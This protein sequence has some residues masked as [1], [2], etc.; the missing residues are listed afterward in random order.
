MPLMQRV[1]LLGRS[2]RRPTRAQRNAHPALVLGGSRGKV[3][4]PEQDW[5]AAD[6]LT[7][8]HIEESLSDEIVSNTA[9]SDASGEDVRERLVFLSGFG[10]VF[11]LSSM[12]SM[13]RRYFRHN[14]RLWPLIDTSLP[15]EDLA[16]FL[17]QQG[18]MPRE[19]GMTLDAVP[20][21][22]GVST[23][24]MG[25]RMLR[26]KAL[27][28]EQR[29]VLRLLYRV[30]VT[31]VWD[32]EYFDM[33]AEHFVD[34]CGAFGPA[35]AQHGLICMQKAL[36]GPWPRHYLPSAHASQLN[37]PV[38]IGLAEFLDLADPYHHVDLFEAWLSHAA[39]ATIQQSTTHIGPERELR[40][41][42]LEVVEDAIAMIELLQ[43]N[44]EQGKQLYGD[45]WPARVVRLHG[46]PE[47]LLWEPQH[48]EQH[49]SATSLSPTFLP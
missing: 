38:L 39:E 47:L 24:Q 11:T 3:I 19:L 41:F 28:M 15:L 1:C 8:L 5:T 49:L 35:P 7:S 17:Y 26:A 45:D 22:A 42:K 46:R 30:P 43:R 12:A 36:I 40:P 20:E 33:A 2:S 16:S 18:A 27:G 48:A 21:V 9:L 29:D 32:D 31:F 25:L 23:G 10:P 14:Q 4:Q 13:I 44:V 6:Y 37:V 34:V